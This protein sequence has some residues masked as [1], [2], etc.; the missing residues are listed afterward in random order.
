MPDRI[1]GQVA[2][3]VSVRE[4]AINRGVDHGVKEGM[5]F[6]ILS[7]KPLQIS[8]PETNQPLININR[9]KVRVKVSTVGDKWAIARTFGPELTFS[10]VGLDI[11]STQ[12]EKTLRV[13]DAELPQPLR[14]EESYVKRGDRVRQVI[15]V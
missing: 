12:K 8:D 1:E 9:E 7:E 11:F 4:V 2:G 3:I 13:Q 15:E 6:A 10:A 5:V 14:E